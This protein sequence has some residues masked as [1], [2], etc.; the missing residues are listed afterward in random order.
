[1]PKIIIKGFAKDLPEKLRLKSKRRSLI[2]R[3]SPRDDS[4]SKIR[5]T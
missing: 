4:F 3:R 2:R 1:M 5:Y